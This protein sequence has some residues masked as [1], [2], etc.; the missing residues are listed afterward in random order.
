MAITDLIE[1]SY[2]CLGS[3]RPITRISNGLH[4]SLTR[5]HH[6]V[7]N[8][9]SSRSYRKVLSTSWYDGSIV[10]EEKQGLPRCRRM[11]RYK[12]MHCMRAISRYLIS[13]SGN[14][15]VALFK[16]KNT[17]YSII[18]YNYQITV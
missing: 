10:L 3:S 13:I 6:R 14:M 15:L 16:L 4:S 8:N 11:E 18:L 1:N 2:G 5:R 9:L 7:L 17:F 12:T